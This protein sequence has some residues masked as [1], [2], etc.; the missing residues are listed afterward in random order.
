M[1]RDRASDAAGLAG[2][3]R[4]HDRDRF[5]TALFA[6][7]EPRAG[8]FALYAFNSE[9]ARV[10]E[11][12][13][14]PL[15][16]EMRLQWWRDAIE[17][18]YSCGDLAHPVA[19][20]IGSAISRHG[21]SRNQFDRL[22]DARAADLVNG[23]PADMEALEAYARGTSS[24]L[25]A[26]ALEVLG[27]R[28]EAAER[29]TL[30]AGIAWAL[31]GLLRAVPFH[32]AQGRVFL[33]GDL[34]AGEGIAPTDLLAA[35]TRASLAK[36]GEAVAER[37]RHHVAAARAVRGSLPRGGVSALLIVTLA[38][39]YLGRLRRVRF[40]LADTTWSTTRPPVARL[41]AAAL[42]RRY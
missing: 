11:S 30:H 36:V 39:S 18:L 33:P 24:T 42:T 5:V 23:P 2:E 21:L 16:G 35:A 13:S 7:A 25:V 10:R 3:V 4:R 41:L 15:L 27:Q 22:I 37:A 19:R 32:A 20:A 1:A 38:N 17:R 9:I 31:T 8:L 40:D 28:G 12:V 29:V 6:P 26:L 34:L 14:E